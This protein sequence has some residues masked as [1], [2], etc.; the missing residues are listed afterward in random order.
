MSFG[1]PGADH[2]FKEVDMSG[3]DE[4]KKER[5]HSGLLGGFFSGQRSDFVLWTVRI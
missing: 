5:A 4:V 3:M 2:V 1:R